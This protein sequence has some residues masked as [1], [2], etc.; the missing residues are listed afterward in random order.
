MGRREEDRRGGV[1]GLRKKG[2][3]GWEC[4]KKVEEGVW[5]RREGSWEG[6]NMVGREG[7]KRF[8]THKVTH[9]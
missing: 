2:G 4:G 3:E 7:W 6:E 1:W 9:L 5:G 8:I